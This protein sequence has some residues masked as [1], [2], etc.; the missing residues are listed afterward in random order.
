MSNNSQTWEDIKAGLAAII[1][2]RAF[3]VALAIWLQSIVF[4]IWP[5]F[6]P[7]IWDNT[8]LLIGAILVALGVIP[9]AYRAA[10]ANNARARLIAQAAA[11]R[12][13]E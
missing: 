4:R 7:D 10:K 6:P 13:D 12:K 5:D 8:K 2:S 11:S 9:A 3:W 1:R